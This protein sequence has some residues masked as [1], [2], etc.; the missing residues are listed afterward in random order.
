METDPARIPFYIA[1]STA[2]MTAVIVFAAAIR[3]GQAPHVTSA[4]LVAFSIS[5]IGILFAKYG[6][7]FGLPWQVY[8]SVPMLATVVMPPA[9]FRFGLARAAVYVLLAFLSAPL[10]HIAFFYGLGWADYMPFLPLPG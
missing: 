4:A 1:A 6:A 7:N 2:V 10:I 5:A 9:I 3:R 8:Y